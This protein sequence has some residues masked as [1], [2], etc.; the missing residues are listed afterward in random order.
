MSN[1][2][3]PQTIDLSPE[4]PVLVGL[5]VDV[6]GSMSSSMNNESGSSLNRLQSFQNSLRELGEK[7]QALS[8]RH[9]GL[10][11]IF[12]YGFGF[13][14]LLSFLSNDKG[15]QVR[16][17]LD[18]SD[19]RESTITLDYLADHW[20]IYQDHIHG[21]AQYM[22]G[23][24][25]MGEGFHK[26]ADRF[27]FEWKKHKKIYLSILFVLS[28]GEPT[29]ESP[30]SIVKLAENLR[31]RGILIVSCFVTSTDVTK[32]RHLYGSYQENWS[33]GAR[34]MFD[35][36]SE[37][38][39]DSEFERYLREHCWTVEKGGRLFT[40]VNQSEIL[41]EFL[42]IVVSPISQLS[43]TRAN[44]SLNSPTLSSFKSEI[45]SPTTREI[46]PVEEPKLP[47]QQELSEKRNTTSE[48]S[49]AERGIALAL[50]IAV[51]ITLIALV[52]NP[53]SMDGG[54]LAIVRFLAATFAGISGYLFS[55]NLGLEA[56]V[57][58]NRTQIRA[59]GAFAAFVILL[60]L[61]FV[62]VPS[63]SAP[64]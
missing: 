29:D 39:A 53:R 8:G 18:K 25:P 28:D 42:G 59:T 14:N 24:T 7:A 38:P 30:E 3:K 44:D 2:E 50:A 52:L 35:C 63:S 20:A 19:E 16:D 13:G 58:L 12:A 10:I 37:L 60:F 41:S 6:S 40:Q 64:R 47:I 5:L 51:L 56:S 15:P 57:P 17:L 54:T 1:L 34:L 48:I 33:Q 46:S 55:G 4:N 9:R 49:A 21:L 62:G 31:S 32:P 61:F 36:A 27:Q 11:K 45:A 26:I 43:E 23:S 22:F